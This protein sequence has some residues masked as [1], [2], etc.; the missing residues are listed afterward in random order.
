MC[1]GG[2][3]VCFCPHSSSTSASVAFIQRS[4]LLVEEV[5]ALLDRIELRPVLRRELLALRRLGAVDGGAPH[6]AAL[7]ARA[8]ALASFSGAP[9]RS[10][11]AFIAADAFFLKLC[12]FTPKSLQ[13]APK[14]PL[15]VSP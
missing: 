1:S 7:A 10:F 4:H 15:T 11:S 6:F 14:V 12:G 8:S 3:I 5:E 9:A 2:A 13:N